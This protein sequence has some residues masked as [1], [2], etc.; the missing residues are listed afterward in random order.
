MSQRDVP[1]QESISNKW[2]WDKGYTKDIP[3]EESMFVPLRLSQ[4][5]SYGTTLPRHFRPYGPTLLFSYTSSIAH[6]G[7]NGY[8]IQSTPGSRDPGYI[9]FVLGL[10]AIRPA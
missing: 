5:C 7:M 10:S 3:P 2:S 4:V 6:E 1:F 9:L 8:Q